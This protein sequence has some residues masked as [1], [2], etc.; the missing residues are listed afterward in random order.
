MTTFPRPEEVTGALPA[1][2]NW[3]QL[4]ADWTLLQAVR[5]EVLKA[6][7]TARNEKQ[8]G[9]GLEA[10]VTIAANDP[11][12]SVLARYE[13]QLRYLLIVSKVNLEKSAAGNGAT[14][15]SVKVSK[16]PGRKCERCWNYSIHV[17][18]NSIYPAVCE[19]CSAVLKEIESH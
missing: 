8:I 7:E 5:N 9:S 4:R 12:Y 14:G 2:E 17:G 10:Q 15:V 18:E 16:A 19:R 6:L 13:D 11:A 1:T 3:E